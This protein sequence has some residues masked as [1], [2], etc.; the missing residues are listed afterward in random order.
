MA[1]GLAAVISAQGWGSGRTAPRSPAAETVTV[2]GSM[3]VANGSPALKSGEITYIV[4]GIDRL[5]GF[6]DGLKEGAEV[7]IEGRSVSNP[8]DDN[9]KILRP[10]KLTI[11][12][13]TYEMAVPNQSSVKPR[14]FSAPPPAPPSNRLPHRNVPMQRQRRQP[15]RQL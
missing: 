13:K 14:Q 7:T 12:G 4:R 1:F 10:A 6:V 3:V 11:N 9:Q 15:M 8:R 5:V 2:S